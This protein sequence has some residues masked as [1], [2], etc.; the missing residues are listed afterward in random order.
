MVMAYQAAMNGGIENLRAVYFDFGRPARHKELTSVKYTCHAL[1]LPLEHVNAVSV[2]D[3]ITGLVV[4]T[5]FESGDSPDPDPI[6]IHLKSERPTGFPIVVEMAAY[7]AALANFDEVHFGLLKEQFGGG[8]GPYLAAAG[9]AR[10]LINPSVTALPRSIAPFGTLSKAEVVQMG[11]SL[12]APLA[13]SWSCHAGQDEH[14]GTCEG[15][16]DRRSA[17][18]SAKVQDRTTYLA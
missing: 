17:F 1:H 18:D 12:N 16:R 13:L 7:H 8:A 15:C 6:D 10:A 2:Q 9:K 5:R 4:N 11:Q 14:C 3:F